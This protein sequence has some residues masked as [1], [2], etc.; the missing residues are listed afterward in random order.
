M[1]AISM[2]YVLALGLLLAGAS[3]QAQVK[4]P[5]ER[6]TATTANVAAPGEPVTIELLKWST[7]ADRDK[8]LSVL[9]WYGDKEVA[10]AM[11]TFGYLWTGTSATGYSIRYAYKVAAADGSQRIILLT[12]RKLGAWTPDTWK[13][14]AA[15]TPDDR[16]FSVIELRVNRAGQGEGKASVTTKTVLDAASKSLAL[17]N[18]AAQPVILKGVAKK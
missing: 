3:A 14:V 15:G 16:P 5:I 10:G 4:G 17:D 18:Y 9:A 11:P 12:D 8:L 13:P 7:D 6:Y 2:K 1:K